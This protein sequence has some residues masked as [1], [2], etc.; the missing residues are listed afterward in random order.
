MSTAPE[1]D[2]CPDCGGIVRFLGTAETGSTAVADRETGNCEG[3]GAELERPVQ[4]GP[5]PWQVVAK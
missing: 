1:E 4:G 3:C 2:P 5:H